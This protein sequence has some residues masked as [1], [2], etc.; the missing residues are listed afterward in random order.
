MHYAKQEQRDDK[1]DAELERRQ[2]MTKMIMELIRL[3][4]TMLP[5]LSRLAAKILATVLQKV[6]RNHPHLNLLSHPLLENVPA[7]QERDFLNRVSPGLLQ[8]TI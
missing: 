5:Y 1:E 3:R 2:N 6:L 8:C 4:R 7:E